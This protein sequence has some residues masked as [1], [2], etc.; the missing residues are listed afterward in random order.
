M[1]N[2]T[3]GISLVLTGLFVWFVTYKRVPI[4][5][6]FFDTKLIRKFLGDIITAYLLYF[7][8][9]VF[10]VVGILLSKGIIL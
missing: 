6:N 1:D 3:A 8:G 2:F 9:A 4:F 10:I 5:W 7:L